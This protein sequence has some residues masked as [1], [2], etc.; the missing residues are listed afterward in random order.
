MNSI[1]SRVMAFCAMV[2]VSAPVLA[3]RVDPVLHVPEPGVLE[4]AGI[5]A[6]VAI[7]VRRKSRRK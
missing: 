4:L 6:I 7:V 2:A 5:A 1:W 3:T